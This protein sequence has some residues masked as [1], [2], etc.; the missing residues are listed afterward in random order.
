MQKSMADLFECSSGNIGLH[1]KNI[2]IEEV[3]Y[4][5]STTEIFSVVRKKVNRNVKRKIEFY[6]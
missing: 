2:F 4:R 5:N 6:N 1:L 3:L